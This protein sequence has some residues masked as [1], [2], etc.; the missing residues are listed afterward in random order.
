MR[1]AQHKYAFL[2][3][4][5]ILLFVL[6]TAGIG[7]AGYGY[8][9][10]ELA[11]ALRE[12]NN[13]L[14]AIADLKARQIADWR[15]E[16]LA[17]AESILTTSFIVSHAQRWLASGGKD[18]AEER[19][20]LA[21]MKAPRHSRHYR[22]VYL[23]DPQGEMRLASNSD[24]PTPCEFTRPAVLEALRTQRVQF[25]DFHATHLS[26][27]VH[28]SLFVPLLAEANG[29]KTA[30]GA[31]AFEIDP[32]HFLYPL[33]QSW[34][35]PSPTAETLLVRREGDSVLYLNELRHRKAAA[36]TVR[37]P[38]SNTA[39]P[40]VRAALGEEG[41]FASKDYRGVEVLSVLRRIPD[42][43]W[44]MVAKIDRSEVDTPLRN[45]A[46]LVASICA[47]LIGLTAVAVILLWRQQ[48][49]RFDLARHEFEEKALHD[50]NLELETRVAERTR[51]LQVEIAQH[52]LTEK[53]LKASLEEL[54]RSN[55]DLEQ[56]AYIASHDMQ[57]PLRM[58]A[59][60]VQLL[61]RRYRDRLDQ[62]AHDFIGYA[63]E[64]ITR[65]QR[66]INDQLTYA[67]VGIDTSQSETTDANQVLA[68]VLANLKPLTEENH[69][70]ISQDVLPAVPVIHSQ[71]G[72]LLQNLIGNAIKFHGEDTPRIHVTARR[73]GNG[74]LFSVSDNGIGIAPEYFDKIFLIFKRLHSREKYPGTGIGLAI[75]KRIVARHHGR[76]WV[77]SELGKGSTFHFTIPTTLE[78]QQPTS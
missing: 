52:R 61:E 6:L 63:V 10:N 22:C 32:H 7:A 39:L 57:E 69:A 53:A 60:Y 70:E 67:L 62:D 77:E 64:G 27:R 19:A 50:A 59:S 74:W 9:Q 78:G 5:L 65:M 66:L 75:C 73:E 38:L 58:V 34:P 23:F 1:L 35:T 71:F 17:E 15:A 30:I 44:F 12:K 2:S 47:L 18:Q 11:H 25:L 33:T 43:P 24:R 68:E 14:A 56:F 31:L 76:I 16:R 29:K 8:W 42:S 28:L 3:W 46:V 21:W 48:Q 20:L 45:R 36:L 54:S 4:R 26:E 72:Q 51:E 40:A 49:M 37:Q 41:P 13:E 55:E